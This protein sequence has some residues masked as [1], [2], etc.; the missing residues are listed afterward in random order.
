MS[1]EAAPAGPVAFGRYTLVERLAVG[2]M[3]EVFR[4]KIV[5]SHGFEKA[6]VIKRILP[7]LAV[8]RTFVSMFIDEAKLTAQLV[9]PKVV[10]VLD[11][12]E[13]DGQYFIALELVDGYD[14]LALLRQCAGRRVRMPLPIGVHAAMEVLD[15]LDYA[16]NALDM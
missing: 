16:H 1:T 10:Q 5:S 11:F 14:A 6:L 2:G 4:A 7:Q 15:A 3:A 8:D 13:V 12:G 9:H